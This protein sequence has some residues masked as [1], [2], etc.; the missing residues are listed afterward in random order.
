MTMTGRGEKG[1]AAVAQEWE[2][3]E[4][5]TEGT[6]AARARRTTCTSAQ[7]E[8]GSSYLTGE[9][10][11]SY[12]SGKD[13]CFTLYGSSSRSREQCDF[14]IDVEI[15]SGCLTDDGIADMGDAHI[16]GPNES[17]DENAC[18]DLVDDGLIPDE[19]QRGVVEYGAVTRLE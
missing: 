7:R 11:G 4:S 15:F 3:T 5:L 10:R 1:A 18:E 13:G 8:R 12:V 2:G 17:L 14:E 19:G 9:G 16:G 6:Q